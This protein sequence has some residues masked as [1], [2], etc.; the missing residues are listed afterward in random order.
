MSKVMHLAIHLQ[1]SRS[2]LAIDDMET[3]LDV[4]REDGRAPSR[5]G[6]AEPRAAGGGGRRARRD[7]ET[8]PTSARRTAPAHPRCSE[9][10]A[11]LESTV[12]GVDRS[13]VTERAK[14]IHGVAGEL[15]TL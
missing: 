1:G 9:G 5:L 12:E 2:G 11:E 15:R 10:L 8:P 4:S 14:A 3:G 6:R 7:T 13:G